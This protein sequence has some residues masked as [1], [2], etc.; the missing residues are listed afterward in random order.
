MTER[1][2]REPVGYEATL[3]TERGRGGRGR[4]GILPQW[5]RSQICVSGFVVAG[6]LPR[7]SVSRKVDRRTGSPTG[8][9]DPETR[10]VG[11]ICGK[12]L[13]EGLEH[14][15]SRGRAA[16]PARQPKRCGA[17]NTQPMIGGPAGPGLCEA[18]ASKPVTPDIGRSVELLEAVAGEASLLG[19]KGCARVLRPH[20]ARNGPATSNLEARSRAH[21]CARTIDQ[22][23]PG[24]FASGAKLPDLGRLL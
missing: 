20:G 5:K 7:V 22:Q 2:S 8:G 6:R 12:F 11:K 13:I 10:R 16:P 4:R 9:S 15:S 17:P 19:S 23:A 3:S 21:N 24:D 14:G 1:V 18:R